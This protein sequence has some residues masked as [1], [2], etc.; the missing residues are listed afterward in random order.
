MKQLPGLPDFV[1][2]GAQKSASTFLQD[3]MRQHPSIEIAVGEARHFEDPEYRNGAVGHLPLLFSRQEPGVVRGIKRP[4]YL[5]RPEVAA[6]IARHLPDA[7]LFVVI[8]E[9]VSRAVS[10]Y[11]HYVRHGFVPLMPLAEAFRRL[12]DCDL[13]GTYPRAGE[14]LTYGLYGLH[15]ERYLQ[16]FDHAQLMVFDQQS[17]TRDPVRSLV[18]AFRFLGVDP[19]FRP[20][21]E[22]VSNRGVYS[23]LR[24]R[25]LRSKNH[26]QYR[27]TPSLDRRYPRRPG[28]LGYAWAGTVATVDRKLLARLDRTRPPALPPDLAGELRRYYAADT[29]RLRSLLP[30]SGSFAWAS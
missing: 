24:L 3:Q 26:I 14:I 2:L 27:Y 20:Q 10:S 29:A 17:L 30:D 28:P 19:S 18:E 9:P 13:Q 11:Y 22:Q 21:R 7:R 12:L 5:G 23:H 4:D 6:R 8:R 15:I 1:I 25:L 16:Y